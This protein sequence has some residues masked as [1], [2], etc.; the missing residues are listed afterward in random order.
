MTNFRKSAMILAAGLGSRLREMTFSTPKALIELNGEPLIK[1]VINKLKSSGFN[2]IV[3]N[4]H[5]HADQIISYLKEN[6]YFETN[7]EIS[8]ESEQLLDTGGAILKALPLFKKVQGILIHNV[9]VVSDVNLDNCYQSFITGGLDGQLLCRD[10]ES[11]RKLLFNRDNILI[12][13]K[14]FQTGETKS[15]ETL[16][17]DYQAFSFSGIHMLRPQILSDFELKKCSVID[18]YLQLAR[19]KK[20]GCNIN[21]EG[22]WFD[23]GKKEDFEKISLLLNKDK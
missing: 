17:E 16:P 21:N 19:S 7:I 12:G 8:D 11:S 3:I 18:I 20:I 22:Y 23:L 4:V 13:W 5:H 15:I 2:H 6:E 14:N 1:I 9:D 10:R